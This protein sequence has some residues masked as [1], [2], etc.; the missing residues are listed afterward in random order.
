MKRSANKTVVWEKYQNIRSS[1]SLSSRWRRRE[2]YCAIIWP[3]FDT[4]KAKSFHYF[5]MNNILDLW[6][7]Q[8]GRHLAAMS[9]LHLFENQWKLINNNKFLP[10]TLTS[11]NSKFECCLSIFPLREFPTL[12]LEASCSCDCVTF[13][14]VL[15]VCKWKRKQKSLYFSLH[16]ATLL[17]R[18]DFIFTFQ[19]FTPTLNFA[20]RR[21]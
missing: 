7:S 3:S 5:K 20:R 8:F 1:L 2:R 4:P 12:K 15:L 21:K 18:A 6:N 16:F 10:S 13:A 14:Q 9:S 11:F 19:C 17:Y